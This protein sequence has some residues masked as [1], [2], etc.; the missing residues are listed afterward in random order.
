[1]SFI[2]KLSRDVKVTNESARCWQKIARY[3]RFFSSQK[4]SWTLK[5]LTSL[6]CRTA[7][8]TT[9]DGGLLKEKNLVVCYG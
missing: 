1:M 4:G 9:T 2:V 3:I 8:I 5:E 6:T 7:G